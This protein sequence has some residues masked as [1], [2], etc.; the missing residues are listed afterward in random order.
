MAE[1]C[2]DT[3][4]C[5]ICLEDF[6]KPK[7]LPCFHTFCEH[8]IDNYIKAH[9]HL[10]KFNCPNCR[11]AI[12][13]PCSGASGFTTN[14]YIHPKGET[15]NNFCTRHKRKEVEFYCRDCSVAGCG[16]CVILDHTTHSKTDLSEV[17]QEIRGKLNIIKREL[18]GKIDEVEKHCESL[19][20]QISDIKNQATKACHNVDIQV[21]RVCGEVTKHGDEIKCEMNKICDEERKKLQTLHEDMIQ[22]KSSLHT[23]VTYINEVLN[24]K[25]TVPV[26]NALTNAQTLTEDS[27]STS[28]DTPLLRYVHYPMVNVDVKTLQTLLGEFKIMESP[29][30][31]TRFSL[32][33]IVKTDTNYSGDEEII[34]QGMS[35]SVNAEHRTG[36][37]LCSFLNLNVAEDKTVKTVTAS[38]SLKLLNINDVSKSKVGQFTCTFTPGKGFGFIFI[39]WNKLEDVTEGFIN[40]KTFDIQATVQIISIERY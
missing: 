24:G 9:S 25:S 39:E 29:T 4:I 13:V 16:S 30:W 28:F 32:N 37:G 21:Q 35:W 36:T 38:Y 6:T 10:N 20:N 11:I 8:C 19:I 23:S 5:S 33:D 18:E 26:V 15:Q 27:R 7:I 31:I 22:F 2:D 1:R 34:I 3:H 12:Q 17:D 40:N 14:I